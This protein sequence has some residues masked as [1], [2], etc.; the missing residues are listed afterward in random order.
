M[1]CLCRIACWTL[2]R[3][4]ACRLFGAK[5]L[6]ETMLTFVANCDKIYG[7]GSDN[8][9][10]PVWCQAIIWISNFSNILMIKRK[11]DNHVRCNGV[12][13]CHL[14]TCYISRDQSLPKRV[15]HMIT[16]MHFGFM[17]QLIEVIKGCFVARRRVLVDGIYCIISTVVMVMNNVM[18]TTPSVIFSRSSTIL[19][20]YHITSSFKMTIYMY[21]MWCAIRGSINPVNIGDLF[22]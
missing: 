15:S 19:K 2:F 11:A 10:S 18:Q 3:S 16:N 17:R 21:T 6:F 14:L 20:T 7:A 8:G 1:Y 5:P 13:G 12:R 22:D 9:L 4:V